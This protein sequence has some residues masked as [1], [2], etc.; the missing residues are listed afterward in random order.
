M[1]T[2]SGTPGRVSLRTLLTP[3]PFLLLILVALLAL[4]LAIFV[5]G[6]SGGFNSPGLAELLRTI[7]IG[8]LAAA[9]TILVDRNLTF[10]NFEVRIRESLR[11]AEG[12][13][14]A[15]SK[16]G[17][18]TAH[19]HFD[20]RMILREA[21]KGETVSWL[22][23]YCPRQNE[24]VDDLTRALRRGVHV[25]MLI[26]DPDCDNARHR[27][28]ELAGTVIE[29]GE[30][31]AAG[32]GAFIAK[33]NAIAES[34]AGSFEIRFY[35]DLPCVPMYLVSRGGKPTRGYFSVFLVRATAHCTH[36]E[37]HKGEWLA[38]MGAYFEAKWSR[39][40]D[41]P[42]EYIEPGGSEGEHAV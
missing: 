14:S 3:N 21:R 24:F 40:P 28:E 38:D 22:D 2:A 1:R 10:R 5:F 16:L 7:G 20:F 9:V 30:D 11:E 32:L 26:I 36:I 13:A 31:W 33:M 25:R 34:G 23:T 41:T 29:T 19:Q 18:Y 15:L 4:I 8:T 39:Q 35:K 37:L 17:V 12:V 6:E 42:P 27:A